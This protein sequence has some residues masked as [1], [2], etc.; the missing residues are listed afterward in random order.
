M[1][2]ASLLV[3]LAVAASCSSEPAGEPAPEF[4][5][6]W[7]FWAVAKDG[8]PVAV[9]QRTTLAGGTEL[10]MRLET[11]EPAR[12]Y[13]V[14]RSGQGEV[15]VLAAGEDGRIHEPLGAGRRL[16]D[17]P[18]LERFHLIVAP[19]PLAALER[20]AKAHRTAGAASRAGCERELLAEVRRVRRKYEDRRSVAA[21]P[22][23]IGGTMRGGA[24]PAAVEISGRGVFCR[25]FT[26]DHR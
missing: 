16:D 13:L 21:K 17:R 12:V 9:D 6:R 10:H 23:Q 1:R 4:W 2:S 11:V 20:L 15:S 18:G 24:A 25:T 19:Q 22:T 8:K 3:G 5:F 26:I 14:H 7:A